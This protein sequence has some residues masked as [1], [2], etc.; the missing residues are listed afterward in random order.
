MA[1]P[2]HKKKKNSGASFVLGLLGFPLL[3]LLIHQCWPS[4]TLIVAV[5]V[6]RTDPFPHT[7]IGKT[8]SSAWEEQDILVEFFALLQQHGEPT[9]EPGK[10]NLENIKLASGI[11]RC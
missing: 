4:Q 7:P 11:K 2:F 5:P 1:F 6:R 3:F 9:F 10:D 8:F